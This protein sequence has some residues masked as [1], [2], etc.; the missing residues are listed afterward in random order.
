[1]ADREAG[2]PPAGG[3]II[4]GEVVGEPDERG[5]EPAK[6]SPGGADSP[7]GQLA[8]ALSGLPPEKREQIESIFMALQVQSPMQSPIDRKITGA[9][10]DRMLDGRARQTELRYQDRRESRW[11]LSAVYGFTGL[12]VLAVV[13]VLALT[14]HDAVLT[15]LI[16]IGIAAAGG[17][18]GGY[19]F[20]SWRRSRE[21]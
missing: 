12:V 20:S 6:D 18:G 11:I 13:L 3:E 15:D 17:F 4:E 2:P 19:G 9:H 14:N 1:V 10:I 8:P 7:L 21:D 5:D 16:K